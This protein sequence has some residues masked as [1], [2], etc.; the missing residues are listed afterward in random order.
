MAPFRSSSSKTFRLIL[1]PSS[2]GGV[3]K[4]RCSPLEKLTYIS[5]FGHFH[6]FGERGG[7]NRI[8]VEGGGVA[9]KIWH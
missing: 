2:G 6:K 4:G 1:D 5:S 7:G 9:E 3:S 8:H